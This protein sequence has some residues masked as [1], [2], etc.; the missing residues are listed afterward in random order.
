MFQ[1]VRFNWLRDAGNNPVAVIASGLLID[2]KIMKPLSI[3]YALAI[4]NPKDKFNKALA[5]SIAEGRLKYHQNATDGLVG[6]IDPDVPNIKLAILN[7]IAS[8]ARK[9]KTKLR[10]H[11]WA[12]A[13]YRIQ[14][15]SNRN[16]TLT[17]VKK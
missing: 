5:K 9:P 3:H 10:P 12:A 2:E 7:K 15:M 6:V 1:N 8:D 16:F 17:P 13:L 4:Y 14:E 11:I